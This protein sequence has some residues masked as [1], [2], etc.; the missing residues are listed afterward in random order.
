MKKYYPR[1]A[2]KILKEELQ[3]FGAV[4]MEDAEVYIAGLHK[5]GKA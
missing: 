1:I 3:A 2:D 5:G 4:L